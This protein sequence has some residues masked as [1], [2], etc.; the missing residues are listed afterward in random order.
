MTALLF[1]ALLG[2]LAP[3][4]GYVGHCWTTEIE[5]GTTD[6]HCIESIYDGAHVR[7]R[8]VVVRGGKAIYAGETIYSDEDGRISLT[9]WNS[10]GGVGRGTATAASGVLTFRLRMRASP[11]AKAE[12]TV[13]TWRRTPAGFDATTGAVTRHFGLD[14]KP[15]R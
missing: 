11:N 1:L 8:H 4:E 5:T 13:T 15:R 7:D 6:R 14:D 10:L 12:E 9:Y 3:F 2:G